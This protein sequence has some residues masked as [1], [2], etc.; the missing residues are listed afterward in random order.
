[1]NY[2]RAIKTGVMLWISVLIIFAALLA[3][4]ALADAPLWRAIIFGIL[5]VP[6]TLF[7][8]KWYFKMDSPNYK[9]G[10]YLGLI[11]LAVSLLLDLSITIPVFV[12]SYLVFFSDWLVYA[13]SAEVLALFIFAGWEFDKTYTT[14]EA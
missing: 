11:A 2:K 4:P 3:V 13:S 1:M 14:L 7:L 9:K 12:K 5:L 8:A 10:I 6:V